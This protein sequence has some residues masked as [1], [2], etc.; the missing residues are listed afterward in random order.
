MPLDGTLYE[1]ETLRVLRVAQERIRDPKNWCQNTYG[2][3]KSDNEPVCSIG[4]LYWV[5]HTDNPSLSPT[6]SQDGRSAFQY[7]FTAAKQL[8]FSGVGRLNDTSNYDT[9]H[10]MFDRAQE[11]RRAEIMETVHA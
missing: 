4:A 10:T 2:Q 11:L 8:G 3:W 1:D 5:V 6:Q 7:L 9:T